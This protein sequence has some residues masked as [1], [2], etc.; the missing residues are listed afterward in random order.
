M[1]VGF[2]KLDPKWQEFSASLRKG[3]LFV[4]MP[5]GKARALYI[6]W[7]IVS[8]HVHER[9]IIECWNLD[10]LFKLVSDE[11]AGSQEYGI[12]SVFYS[13][14][15]ESCQKDIEA[16]QKFGEE[17]KTGVFRLF[18]ETLEKGL[19]SDPEVDWVSRVGGPKAHVFEA[20]Q[21]EP[22]SADSLFDELFGDT[23][24]DDA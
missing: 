2:D 12:K 21:A 11:A 1:H 8:S 19:R 20:L 22:E 10:K 9:D 13:S 3:E 6:V 14:T 17:D 23:A 24:S 7:Q 16:L 18:K 4:K 15:V 5:I